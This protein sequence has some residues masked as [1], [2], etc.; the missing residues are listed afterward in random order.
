VT[1]RSFPVSTH[2]D[3]VSWLVIAREDCSSA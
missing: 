1:R 2:K 3:A